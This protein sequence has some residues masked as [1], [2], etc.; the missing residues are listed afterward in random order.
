MSRIT[1]KSADLP[2]NARL[3]IVRHADSDS[4]SPETDGKIP[5]RHAAN[6]LD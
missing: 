6:P 3:S 4:P 1:R 2:M 5:Q